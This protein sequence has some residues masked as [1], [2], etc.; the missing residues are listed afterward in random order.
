MCELIDP[1]MA[2]DDAGLATAVRRRK[3]TASGRYG[4]FEILLDAAN[5][6][7]RLER[8]LVALRDNM[9]PRPQRIILLFGCNGEEDADLRRF[10]GEVAHYRADIVV[11]TNDSPR[12][13]NPSDIVDD[14][15]AGFPER[16]FCAYPWADWN[17]LQDPGNIDQV[18]PC[19]WRWH[20]QSCSGMT[21][22]GAVLGCASDQNARAACMLHCYQ[23]CLLLV[24][25]SSKCREV[26]RCALLLRSCRRKLVD[27]LLAR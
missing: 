26:Q 6:P 24:R 13:E 10:M 20:Q 23:C 2:P 11:I 25:I 14:I 27:L 4:L 9:T 19:T 18:R 1:P 15:T 8:L 3:D 21:F 16:V 17:Y 22:A 12:R 7:A 5:T